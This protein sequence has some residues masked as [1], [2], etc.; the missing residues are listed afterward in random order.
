M[1]EKKDLFAAEL[2]DEELDAAS[3]GTKEELDELLRLTGVDEDHLFEALQKVGVDGYII[4]D[5]YWFNNIYTDREAP[6]GRISHQELVQRINVY[7]ATHPF[8]KNPFK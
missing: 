5:S 4:G 1:E 6:E 2:S 7:K 8:V 3:G